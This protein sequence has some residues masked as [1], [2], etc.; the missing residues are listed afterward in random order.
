MQNQG[1]PALVI[2]AWSF[3]LIGSFHS[4]STLTGKERVSSLRIFFA[5]QVLLGRDSDCPC[6]SESTRR[7][8]NPI[9][10]EIIADIQ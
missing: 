9:V 8:H 2:E 10:S 3:I 4:I 7:Y 1:V 6:V 5:Y